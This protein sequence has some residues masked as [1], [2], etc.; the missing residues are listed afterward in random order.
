ME[1][2]KEQSRRRTELEFEGDQRMAAKLAAALVLW[3]V[4]MALKKT[5]QWVRGGRR[6]EAPICKERIE[7]SSFCLRELIR[8]ECV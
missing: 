6:R 8:A 2:Y 4:Q 1:R 5:L 3:Q 7:D